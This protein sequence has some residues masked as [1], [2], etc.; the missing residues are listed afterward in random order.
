MDQK[1]V[2]RWTDLAGWLDGWFEAEPAE[3]ADFDA[4]ELEIYRDLASAWMSSV[5]KLGALELASERFGREPVRGVIRKLCAA[6]T[7]DHWAG[8]TAR[9]GR[10]LDDLFRLLWAPLPETGFDFAA[11][12][13]EAGLRM[14]VRRCPFADLARDLQAAGYANARDWLYEMVCSTDFHVTATFDPPIR[15]SRRQ[16]LM[17]GAPCCDH[18]YDLELSRPRPE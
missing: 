12:R 4:G 8:L 6:N 9:E 11:E 14:D 10:S 7:S 3:S 13:D 17:Q 15:F 16:T 18:T 5:D 2:D 1:L